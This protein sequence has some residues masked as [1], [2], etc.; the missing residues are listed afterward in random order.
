MSAP[1]SGKFQDHYIVLGLDP[2]SD[3][4]AIQTAYSKL[5]QKYHPNNAETGDEN[6]F[7]AVNLAYEVLSD[8]SLRAG[9]DQVKGVDHEAGNPKF[10]GTAFFQALE[11]GAALRAAVL[12]ILYDRRRV[13]SFK[14]SLSMR[15]LESMLHVTAEQLNFALWYLKQRGLVVN[16]DKSSM[17]ITVE[18]MDHLEQ[19]RPSA[20][21]VMPLI[22]PSALAQ[23][24]KPPSGET[25]AAEPVLNVLSRALQRN[26]ASE[27][28]QITR[29]LNAISVK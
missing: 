17:E 28:A 21:A 1:V 16:D 27:E 24:E 23:P 4:E 11:Q 18:G 29:S 14:P 15:H 12:C 20:D 5:A 9:F 6:K 10:T 8:P 19:N 25:K 3:S 2:K 7:E 22:K 26:T 13:K